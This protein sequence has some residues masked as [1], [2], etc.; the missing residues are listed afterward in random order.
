MQCI[1]Y[2]CILH[3]KQK[4]IQFKQKKHVCKLNYTNILKR[5]S[6][7]YLCVVKMEREDGV[8][9]SE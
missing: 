5:E 7:K 3:L 2:I 4:M 8:F 9:Y 6:N 1:S